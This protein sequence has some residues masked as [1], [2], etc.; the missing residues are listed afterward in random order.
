M[1]DLNEIPVGDPQENSRT[2]RIKIQKKSKE[3][4]ISRYS[5]GA[6]HMTKN[7]RGEITTYPRFLVKNKN[8]GKK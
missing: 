1:S 8:K 6:V 2:K 4:V 7:R 5:D 3:L